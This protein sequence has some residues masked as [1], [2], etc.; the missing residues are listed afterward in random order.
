MILENFTKKLSRSLTFHLDR[1]MLMTTLVG[2]TG[3]AAYISTLLR[4]RYSN[5]ARGRTIR[6]PQW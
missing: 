4:S 3:A 2:D 1:K 6:G 5:C